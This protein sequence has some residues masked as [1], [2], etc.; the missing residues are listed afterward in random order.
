MWLFREFPFLLPN[1]VASVLFLVGLSTGILFLKVSY[2]SPSE[3]QTTSKTRGPI[4]ETL[5]TKK[6]RRDYGRIL[7][8]LLTRP[9]QKKSPSRKWGKGTEQAASLLKDSPKSP[10]SPRSTNIVSQAPPSFREVFSPQSNLNLMAYTL[11]ALHSIA[12]DQLLPVFLHLPPQPDRST[13]PDVH[14][15][16]K[17]AGGFDLEVS[18]R[19]PCCTTCTYPKKFI[20]TNCPTSLAALASSSR[21]VSIHSFGKRVYR[22]H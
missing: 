3:R 8:K 11:L 14:L 18:N 5:E 4:Q 21:C 10:M 16:F 12:Y 2:L 6:H 15:P 13:N 7:G 9:F 1:L 17:F 20:D 22:C 19:L